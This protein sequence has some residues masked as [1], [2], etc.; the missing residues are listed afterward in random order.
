MQFSLKLSLP[1]NENCTCA[2]CPS[3]GVVE[4]AECPGEEARNGNPEEQAQVTLQEGGALLKDTC[5][6]YITICYKNNFVD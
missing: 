4:Q 2:F 3:D 6:F 1:Q 5:G